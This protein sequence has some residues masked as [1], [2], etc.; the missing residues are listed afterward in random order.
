MIM[1]Y[2]LRSRCSHIRTAWDR[3][4]NRSISLLLALNLQNQMIIHK[5]VFEAVSFSDKTSYW[6]AYGIYASMG[7]PFNILNMSRNHASK[8]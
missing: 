5:Y 4:E 2:R 6:L 8:M 3:H 1:V 7:L